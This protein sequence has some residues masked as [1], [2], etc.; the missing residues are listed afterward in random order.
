MMVKI[1]Y[2]TEELTYGIAIDDKNAMK[3][4]INIV[5]SVLFHASNNSSWSEEDKDSIKKAFRIASV[6]QW[7][8]DNEMVQVQMKWEDQ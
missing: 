4:A 6:F 2:D 8:I 5:T 1:P 3:V 7:W